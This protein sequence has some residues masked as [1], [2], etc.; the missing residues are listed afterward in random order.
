MSMPKV[1]IVAGFILVILGIVG[2]IISLQSDNFSPTAFIP[3]ALGVVLIICGILAPKS[4][5]SR[6][7]TMHIAPL[8]ALLGIFGSLIPGGG[9]DFSAKPT[10]ST[11]KLLTAVTCAVY[12]ILCVRSFIVAR[13]ARSAGEQA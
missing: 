6:I 2:G 9:L 8:V 7:I 11:F 4:K 12:V 10:P 13:K 5:K 1:T 3:A